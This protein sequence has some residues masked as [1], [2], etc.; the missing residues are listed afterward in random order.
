MT[1]LHALII[2]DETLVAWSLSEHLKKIGFETTITESGQEGIRQALEDPPDVIF[3]DYRLPDTNGIEILRELQP[4]RDETN[5]FFMTA[6]GT[7]QVAIEAL[8]L[9]AREYLNKPVNFDEVTVMV[10]RALREQEKS[11]EI[12]VLKHQEEQRF[13][14]GAYVSQSQKMKEVMETAQKLVQTDTG[15]ILLLGET[16]TGKDTLA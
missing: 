16:G 9:G 1:H 11:R 7:E 14:L 10:T 3:L 13:Q 5:F 4:I 15:T 8:K 2:E 12:S 6:Y